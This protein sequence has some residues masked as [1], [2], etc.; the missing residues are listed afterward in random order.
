MSLATKAIFSNFRF[1][2]G[3]VAQAAG[4]KAW[5]LAQVQENDKPVIVYSTFP[6]VTSAETAGARL[7]EQKLAACVNILPGM[8]AIYRWEGK[9]ARDSEAVM[10]IKTRASLT[11]AV[12]AAVKAQ[13]PYSTPALLVLPIEGGAEAYLAW[14]FE[15]T[16]SP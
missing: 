8:T 16:A 10:I 6:S 3:M 5:R 12:I 4:T 14:L 11:D 15:E 7:V 9:I 1:G 2:F 13:H